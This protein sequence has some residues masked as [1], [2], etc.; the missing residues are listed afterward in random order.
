MADDE[1]LE[2]LQREIAYEEDKIK[3]KD[4]D[5]IKEKV[6]TSGSGPY[7]CKGLGKTEWHSGFRAGY[8]AACFKLKKKYNM[9]LDTSSEE[10]EDDIGK[11]GSSSKGK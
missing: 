10:E 8:N 6:R 4:M 3:E 9:R 2:A 5:K 1:R 11:K 7:S